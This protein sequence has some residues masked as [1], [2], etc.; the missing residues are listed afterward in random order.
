M[1]VDSSHC[2]TGNHENFSHSLQGVQGVQAAGKVLSAR[3]EDFTNEVSIC[4]VPWVH[5]LRE[6]TLT[7]IE[8]S[9][10]IIW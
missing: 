9:K 3:A 2:T 8:P 5:F 6:Y 7:H 4:A 10:A 1:F